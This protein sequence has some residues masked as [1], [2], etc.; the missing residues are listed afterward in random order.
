MHGYD[1]SNLTLF[2]GSEE[3]RRRVTAARPLIEQYGII[4]YRAPSLLRTPELLE[5]LATLYRYDSSIPTS[6]GLFP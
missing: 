6:G 1:H 4:G 2:A 5:E 3:R